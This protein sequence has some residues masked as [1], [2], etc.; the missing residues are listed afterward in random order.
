MREVAKDDK[1]FISCIVSGT[2]ESTDITHEISKI[3]K[4]IAHR[5]YSHKKK[6][7]TA[8]AFQL[9]SESDAY[10]VETDV[11]ITKDGVFIAFHD[12]SAARL[13][14]RYK[15]IEKTDFVKV[16][17]LK[18]YDKNRRHK[19]P[20][21]V[22]YLHSCK[23]SGKVAVV[24]IKSDLTNEQTDRL[25]GIINDEGYLENTIFVSFN[26]R[27]LKYIRTQLPEQLIQL[28]MLMFKQE[29][30]DFVQENQFG[31]DISHRQLTK[32]RIN[33]CHTRGIEVNCWT[34]NSSKRAKILQSWGV[35]YITTDKLLLDKTNQ[36]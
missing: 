1:S 32:D 18:V 7:N 2:A 33:E 15:V 26:A 9:A 19:I 6:Q 10:G 30:L 35:D 4:F 16:R 34:V 17:K 28:L 3:T 22:E 8:D 12:K 5:G 25:I 20:T 23:S 21:F 31:I 11:R 13:S 29:H 27:I 24:E 14:G 36:K